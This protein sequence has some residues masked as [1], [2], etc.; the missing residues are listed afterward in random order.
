MVRITRARSAQRGLGGA[1]VESAVD[2][3]RVGVDD[4]AAG[5]FG[6]AQRELALAGGG[7]ADDGQHSGHRRQSSGPRGDSRRGDPG[8]T[9]SAR[10][11]GRARRARRAVAVGAQ[12]AD[13]RQLAARESARRRV[14]VGV[15]RARRHQREPRPHRREQRRGGRARRAVVRDLQHVGS[16]L[17][18]RGDGRAPARRRRRDPPSRRSRRPAT[19]TRRTSELALPRAGMSA[20][21][22]WST[23]KVMAPTATRSRAPRARVGT[24]R[25]PCSSREQAVGVAPRGTQ[26]SATG[27]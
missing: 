8:S 11:R 4:L 14:A 1:D 21:P 15:A 5:R 22:G 19:A 9:R 13:A 27:R 23:S 10:A 7:G 20:G 16:E 3:K 6:E 2:L 24:A 18:D 25:A 17:A 12:D 26:S